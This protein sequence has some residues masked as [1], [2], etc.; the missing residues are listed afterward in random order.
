MTIVSLWLGSIVEVIRLLWVQCASSH[1]N[2]YIHEQLWLDFVPSS[3]AEEP[4]LQTP[5]DL[6]IVLVKEV[7]PWCIAARPFMFKCTI[8]FVLTLPLDEVPYCISY[9]SSKYVQNPQYCH[10][11]IHTLIRWS[12]LL[13]SLPVRF[14]T[15]AAYSYCLLIERKGQLSSA[16]WYH[17]SWLHIYFDP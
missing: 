1:N 17:I 5:L 9:K 7:S 12:S 3:S 11:N 15:V 8:I 2:Y 16:H 6:G 10:K 4:L 13:A 14:L